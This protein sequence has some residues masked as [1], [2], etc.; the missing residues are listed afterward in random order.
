VIKKTT[1]E[2]PA[3]ATHGG[4]R[5]LNSL[6]K[7]LVFDRLRGLAWIRHNI[8]EVGMLENILPSVYA[9]EHNA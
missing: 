4:K 7:R 3:G 1:T 2:K 8:E 6:I 9:A 5:I